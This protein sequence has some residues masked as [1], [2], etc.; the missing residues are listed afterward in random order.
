[1]G[2][3]MI[4]CPRTGTP[5][6]TGVET[7]QTG[8]DAMPDGRFVMHCWQCGGDHQWSKRWAT[9]VPDAPARRSDT[10]VGASGRR[11]V[12]V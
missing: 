7:D 12:R 3:I 5:V 6:P 11:P 9:F 2:A 1:M 4:L 8:Y 10:T